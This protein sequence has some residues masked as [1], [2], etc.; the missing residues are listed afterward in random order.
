MGF[1][2]EAPSPCQEVAPFS[3]LMPHGVVTLCHDVRLL[4]APME[5]GIGVFSSDFQLA[6][7]LSFGFLP[8]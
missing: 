6:K 7:P 1:W 2:V 5:S 4:S 3:L 8:C